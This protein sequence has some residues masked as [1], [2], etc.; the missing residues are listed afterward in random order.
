MLGD[1]IRTPFG[2]SV[3]P[4]AVLLTLLALAPVAYI[5]LRVAGAARDV[6]YW[7]EYDT[8]LNL[9]LQLDHGIGW[10]D[11]VS[12]LF[13]VS[14]EHRMV[15]SRLM[16]A[17]SYWLTGT[18]NF[19]VISWIGN[20]SLVALC[21]LLVWGVNT[22][23]RRLQ[24]GFILAM[25]LFQLEH[26]E[27]FL[28]S[29]S[30]IDHF[31]V[32][33]LAGGAVI[34]IARNTRRG[35]LIGALCAAL[36]TFTLAH[37]ILAWPVGAWMLWR[38]RRLRE[39]QV[40]SVVALAAAL[41][42]LAGFRVN[43]SER[44]AEFSFAGIAQIL[45]Y[46]LGL[47]GAVPSLG[48]TTAAPWL[49]AVLLVALGTVAYRG[50]SRRE[51]V[52]FPLAM[53]AIAALGLIAIGRAAESQGVPFSRYFVLS[54]VA[55]ALTAFMWVS[56]LSHPR[57][58]YLVLSGCVP[59]LVL[60]NVS[61]DRTFVGKADS[62]QECRDRA[63]V[64]FE[65]HGVDGRGAFALYPVPS[66]STQ[67]LNEAEQREIYRMSSMCPEVSYPKARPSSRITYNVDELDV[68]GRSAAIV[69]WFAIPGLPAKRGQLH[70][71]LRSAHETHV[72]KTVTVTRPDVAT[73]LHRPECALSGF[74]FARRRDRLPTGD[75]Q[76]G[77]LV[78]LDHGQ[79]YIMTDYKLHLTNVKAHSAATD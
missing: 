48:N 76:V 78:T 67:L 72:F 57:R 45:R 41:G 32:V 20:L 1:P 56:R 11:F 54:G 21:G 23:A 74:S 35:L 3:R 2:W 47:L 58:P 15:T 39:L 69:G 73:A 50:A 10:R 22:P 9:V 30:S 63:A 19:T 6:A 62:W 34:G 25:L 65:Q 5:G 29:G 46:W 40:W 68:T 77:F 51:T 79:E 66:R 27:N 4:A 28:W 60:F 43:A 8:A 31:Q 75:Y 16:F 14:N 24:M 42:F 55:W 70:V 38:Q 61:A 49:G 12:R 71:V 44:F 64:H 13:E 7:D 36:A 26:Y 53:Y 37:G 18:V 17:A 59:A 52:A 33:L